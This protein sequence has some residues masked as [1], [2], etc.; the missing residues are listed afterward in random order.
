VP[1]AMRV[2]L[3]KGVDMCGAHWV[4]SSIPS[5]FVVTH[6]LRAPGKNHPS[7]ASASATSSAAVSAEGPG[8][9]RGA[10]GSAVTRKSLRV[11]RAAHDGR[12]ARS[13]TAFGLIL[14]PADP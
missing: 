10:R 8:A 3:S 7:S 13:T 14:A 2:D 12:T 1:A 6:H 4:C 9:G 5:S 11:I